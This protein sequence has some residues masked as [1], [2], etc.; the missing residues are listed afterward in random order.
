MNA[1]REPRE[2]ITFAS[3]V[4]CWY[5]LSMAMRDA[6]NGFFGQFGDK[7]EV[8]G[9]EKLHGFR[10]FLVVGMGGSHFAAD[11][12]LMVKPGLDLIVHRDYGLPEL[13]ADVWKDRL[14]ICSSYSG[15]TEEVI[16]AFYEAREKG[17][18]LAVLSVGG[19]LLELAG[20][21][22]AP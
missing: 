8:R 18:P 13:P 3:Y 7:P 14:V 16:G 11:F 21:H 6:I 22:V 19:K 10:K 2:K 12:L 9:Q 4:F 1:V 20:E 5:S 15:N 17:L